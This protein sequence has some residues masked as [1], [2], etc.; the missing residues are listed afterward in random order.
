MIT[1]IH[2]MIYSDDAPATREFFRDVL[3]LPFVS[4]G[5][6]G[7]GG[8]DWLIFASG[9]S[10]LGVHPTFSTWEGREY[11]HARHHSISMMCDNIHATVAELKGRGAEFEGEVQDQGYGLVIMMRVP[12]ADD[13]QLYEPRHPVAYN[14][15]Q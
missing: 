12:G 8:E 3:N 13:V 9:P 2:N 5:E 1:S 15:E 11:R 14:L 10:E 4:M 6:E 7:M